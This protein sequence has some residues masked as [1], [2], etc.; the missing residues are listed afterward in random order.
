MLYEVDYMDDLEIQTGK[1]VGSC[2]QILSWLGSKT[3]EFKWL[4]RE[5]TYHQLSQLRQDLID[6]MVREKATQSIS[7]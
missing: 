1:T 5:S 2:K 4:K 7:A 6:L 3:L